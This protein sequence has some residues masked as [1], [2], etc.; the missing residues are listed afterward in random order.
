MASVAVA[1][2]FDAAFGLALEKSTGFALRKLGDRLR[3]RA[4]RRELA[5]VTA[6]SIEAAANAVPSLSDDFRSSG[7]CQTILAPAVLDIT[8]NPLDLP[9]PGRLA[10]AFVDVVAEGEAEIA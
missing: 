6:R 5:A 9:D 1:A 7:F 2:L 10:A 4:E 3:R 8:A